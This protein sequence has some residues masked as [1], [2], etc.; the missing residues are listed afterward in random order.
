MM[1]A[2][3]WWGISTST[4]S[5]VWPDFSSS[6]RHARGHLGHRALEH[7]AAVRH[8]HHVVVRGDRLGRRRRSRAAGRHPEDL[9]RAAVGA[10]HRAL[11]A[12][13]IGRPHDRGARAV[14]EQDARAAVGEVE[15]AAED[16]GADQ[17]DRVGHARRDERGGRRQPVAEPGARGVDVERR[18][19][20]A[21]LLL[22]PHRRRRED[23]VAGD[24]GHHDHVELLGRDAGG[25]ERCARRLDRE[26][27]GLHVVVGE[28]AG[29]DAGAIADPLV[30][31][32]D[33]A[34]EPGVGH[35]SR[36]ERAADPGD[37]GVA[38]H[39]AELTAAD[40]GLG[41]ADRERRRARHDPLRHLRE[42][43]AG[44]AFQERRRAGRGERLRVFL[45]A[46]RRDDVALEQ[47]AQLR[48]VVDRACRSRSRRSGT[49]ARA[50]SSVASSSRIGCTAGSISGEWNAP[51]TLQAHGADLPLGGER[52]GALDRGHR[53]ADHRL[54]GGVAVRDDQHARRRR[55]G[56]RR[57]APRRRRGRRRAARVIVPGRASPARCM[58]SPRTTTTRSA[59]R[60]RQH[61]GRHQGRELAERV[62]RRADDACEPLGLAAPGTP[63][64]RTRAAPAAR[65]RSSRGRRRRARRRRRRGPSPRSPRRARPCP[66][67]ARPTGRPCRRTASPAPGR[68]RRSP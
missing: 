17:Q 31:R 39:G 50:S 63:R 3:A 37:G 12:G 44:T 11:D 66:P 18:A 15:D 48:R 25:L 8:A 16:L 62:P 20:H 28:V 42:H 59:P 67:G 38:R 10:E 56:P 58:A 32:L 64:R 46:D 22:H 27:G 40:G 6:S 65:T 13:G 21:E 35:E 33:E 4:S 43:V 9:G 24:R 14:A 5:I 54:R 60:K 51:A 36:R 55:R 7:L 47:R 1:R 49:R 19:A 41:R 53:A 26:V 34:L 61:P 23:R 45:P 68:R 2:F 57:R 52:L 30:V 29:L